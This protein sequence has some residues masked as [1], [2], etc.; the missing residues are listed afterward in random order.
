M[1]RNSVVRNTLFM[2]ISVIL[3]AAALA[4]VAHTGLN[5]L[6]TAVETTTSRVLE[7]QAQS[8]RIPLPEPP[9]E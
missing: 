8:R 1:F 2:M 5:G 4:F 6:L 7:E 9:V 3:L